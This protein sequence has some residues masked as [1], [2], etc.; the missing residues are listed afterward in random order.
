MNEQAAL[1]TKDNAKEDRLYLALELSHK[2]WKLGFS[3]GR[4]MQLASDHCGS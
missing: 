2:S 3:D 4:S 1:M